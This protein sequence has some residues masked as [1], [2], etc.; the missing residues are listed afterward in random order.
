MQRKDVP[1]NTDDVLLLRLEQ[2]LASECSGENCVRHL[3]CVC[4]E[5]S[6]VQRQATSHQRLEMTDCWGKPAIWYIL[7]GLLLKLSPKASS[8]RKDRHELQHWRCK[9]MQP[10]MLANQSIP[11]SAASKCTCMALAAQEMLVTW[12][13]RHWMSSTFARLGLSHMPDFTHSVI[14]RACKEQHDMIRK[15][16]VR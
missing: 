16:H 13:D 15:P 10:C 11:Q 12:S 2:D 3:A 7:V 4:L 1:H 9:A 6:N 5:E 14:R 8:G